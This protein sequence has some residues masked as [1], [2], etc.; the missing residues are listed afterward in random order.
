MSYEKELF[1]LDQPHGDGELYFAWQKGNGV[2]LA[3][4]GNDYSVAIFN[5]QGKVHE[6]IKLPGQCTGFG[7][8]CDGDLLGLICDGSFSILFWDSNTGKKFPIDTGLRDS[9]TV[10]SWALNEPIVAVGSA[11]GNLAIYNHRTSKRIPVLGKHS[12]RIV[13]AAW[14]STN[15]LALGSEDRTIS[16]NNS[17]GDTL[18]MFQLSADPSALQF[19]QFQ[20]D[21]RSSPDTMVSLIVGK[22][23]LLIYNLQEPDDPIKLAF[24]PVYGNIVA[25]E[26][27]K[28]G[29]IL[30]GFSAGYLVCTSTNAKELGKELFQM[31]NHHIRLSYLSICSVLSKV[32]TCGDNNVKIHELKNLS[33]VTAIITLSDES[34]VDRVG[35]SDD[36]QLI[37]VATN[38]GSAVVYVSRLAR[39]YACHTNVI[40]ILTS[41]SHITVF[42]VK[43]KSI[44]A[45]HIWTE[46][47]PSLLAVGPYHLVVGMNNRT[48]IY[49]LNGDPPM[50][51]G[52]PMQSLSSTPSLLG[53]REYMGN[54]TNIHLNAEYTAALFAGKLHLH[55]TESGTGRSSGRITEEKEMKIFPEPGEQ[56]NITC[57][58]LTTDFLVYAS[59]LGDIRLF[60]LDDWKLIR[61]YKHSISIKGLY[62]DLVATR[63]IIIDNKMEGYLYSPVHNEMVLIPEFPTTTTGALWDQCPADRNV[64]IAFDSTTVY[65]FVHIRDSIDGPKIEKVGETKLPVDQIPL[66]LQRG[67]ITLQTP[68]GKL[69]NLML[70]TH[71]NSSSI[72][73]S[74]GDTM[75]ATLERHIALLRYNDAWNTCLIL[76]NKEDWLKLGNAALRNLDVETALKVFRHI[77][78][79]G[80]V[81]S[82]QSIQHIENKK[83][84]SGHIAEILGEFDKAQTLYLESSEPIQALVMRQNLLQWDQALQLAR[85]LAPEQVPSTSLEY[86]N[87]LELMGNHVESLVHFERAIVDNPISIPE[88]DIHNEKCRSG[89][90]RT[91]LRVGDYRRGMAI[92]NDPN[93]PA[94]LKLQ[95]A[96]IME[97]LKKH[98][99]AALLYESTG[100][101]DKAAACYISLKNWKKVG[102]LLPEISDMKIYKQYAK[103]KESDS[104]Y[105]AAAQAYHAAG[106]V[107]NVVRLLIEKLNQ[108]QKAVAFVQESRNIEA[109]KRVA[110]F[111]EKIG[112]YASALKFLVMSR[113]E[114]EALRLCKEHGLVELYAN[115]VTEEMGG[116]EEGERQLSALAAHFEHQ[117]NLMLAAKCYYHAA[118]FNKALRTLINI[119]KGDPNNQEAI[120][121]AIE[122]VGAANDDVMANQLIELLLGDLDGEARDPKYVFKLY[123]ARKQYREAAKTAIIIAN[124]ELA[125]GNYSVAHSVLL[126]MC[127]DLHDNG[128][129]VTTELMTLLTLLH[130]YRLVR[131]H[132]KRGDH[133]KAAR[134]LLRVADNISKFPAHV[135]PILTSTV[136]ECHRADLK[137]AAFNYAAMLMRPEHKSK[138]EEK[139]LKKLESVVRKPPKGPDNKIAIDKPEETSP[140]PYCDYDLMESQLTCPQCRNNIPFCIATGRHIVKDDFTV[141]PNCQFPGIK[142]ELLSLLESGVRCPM[143]N[144][145]INPDE[146]R[147]EIDFESYLSQIND[148]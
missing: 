41:L 127:M 44:P 55:L 90:A 84:I 135:V 111:F 32:A 88:I 47:E 134:M 15:V 128:L 50:P 129:P 125:N 133:Y 119:A 20:S 108:P 57:H 140:C 72:I 38:T 120:I 77:G 66:L 70:T 68:G 65:T 14:G 86:A 28:D 19:T 122:V 56:M 100:N 1:R 24:E 138:I 99:E 145:K 92:A 26:W 6:R 33:D 71:S 31:K 87:Q 106:D 21:D 59:D 5:R 76:N 8:D 25:Y 43:E 12:K 110:K 146:L 40:A 81:T 105:Q 74:Q 131:L 60:G 30:L 147:V 80:M 46:V 17:D 53:D 107:E 37:C 139:Y 34:G 58:A 141:C 98:N 3:T 148:D 54:V 94:P 73:H 48:W 62:S 82:L 4:V 18:K 10:I 118:Q 114:N 23:M 112:D 95:C 7:W 144:E 11:R 9:L 101:F 117:G 89:I 123:R 136:I 64:F 97:S 35:W 130:S 91:S 75:K 103:A 22:K 39:L 109:A 63:V 29:Y 61:E 96:E 126:G 115:I 143:C 124:E 78:D 137:G 116:S 104:D 51:S 27:Y 16:I 93:C 85:N 52:E 83:L 2:Y 67:S 132:V 142:S 45:V 121:L 102:Q 69:T 113:S 13:T 42:L 36:G 49:D 79:I